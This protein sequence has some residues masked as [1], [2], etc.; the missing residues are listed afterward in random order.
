MPA[1]KRILLVEDSARDAELILDALA[2]HQ[3]ANEMVHVRDGAEAP[4]VLIRRTLQELLYGPEHPLST[5]P[6]GSLTVSHTRHSCSWR[7]FAIS[8]E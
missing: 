1:L 8:N 3:L 6:S 2:T 5:L 7:G 4:S